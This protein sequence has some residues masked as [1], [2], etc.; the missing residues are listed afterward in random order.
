MTYA[1]CTQT[2]GAKSGIVQHSLFSCAKL[3][4]LSS[5]PIARQL[6]VLEICIDPASSKTFS[7]DD[8][9]QNSVLSMA[10]P[11]HV[12]MAMM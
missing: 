6:N 9:L 7:E 10:I 1:A 4:A 12:D 11:I 8:Q 5:A 2:V 3:R